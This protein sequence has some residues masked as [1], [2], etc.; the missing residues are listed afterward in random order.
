M[1]EICKNSICGNSG[2]MHSDNLNTHTGECYFILEDGTECK[3]KKFET[4]G[5]KPSKH[6][7]KFWDEVKEQQKPQNHEDFCICKECKPQLVPKE[8]IAVGT[9]NHSPQKVSVSTE[10]TPEEIGESHIKTENT[11]GTNSQQGISKNKVSCYPRI[12]K[13]ADT[14]N[15]K[16]KRKELMKTLKLSRTD[17]IDE[18]NFILKLVKQQDKEFI[19]RLK[20][21]ILEVIGSGE[22]VYNFIDKLAGN[23]FR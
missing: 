19:K 9:K 11:S 3:C 17:L 22:S 6:Q 1:T 7:K 8:E 4:L 21:D 5:F 14:F 2:L 15:L 10:D 20:E 12:D 18:I 16:E 23:K 13:P